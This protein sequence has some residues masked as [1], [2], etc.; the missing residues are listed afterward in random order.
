MEQTKNLLAAYEKKTG[1]FSGAIIERDREKVD[2]ILELI[3]DPNMTQS[4]IAR[5]MKVSRNTVAA[6]EHRAELDGRLAAYKER[7]LHKIRTLHRMAT[8]SLMEAIQKDQISAD[9][10]PIAWGIISDH[11]TKFEGMPTQIHEVRREISAGELDEKIKKIKMELAEKKVDAIE[12]E[13][14]DDKSD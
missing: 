13:Q 7:A 8:D 10:K 2:M 3:V 4:E 6:L 11:L 1:Q 12:V 5:R 14:G 9:K